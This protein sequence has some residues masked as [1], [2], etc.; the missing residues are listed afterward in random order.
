MAVD[1]FGRTTSVIQWI[2]LKCIQSRRWPILHRKV[3]SRALSHPFFGWEGS[4]TKIDYLAPQ[5]RF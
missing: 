5:G 1:E 2:P 4:P 3:P